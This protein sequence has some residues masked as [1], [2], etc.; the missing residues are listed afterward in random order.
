ML[1]PEEPL[2][3]L[4]CSLLHDRGIRAETR[5][6]KH[7]DWNSV[8]QNSSYVPVDYTETFIDYQ[9][10][11]WTGCSNQFVECSAII[12]NDNQPCAVW[13]VSLKN[14]G[15][16]WTIGS[17]GGHLL[18]PQF[19]SDLARKTQKKV[20]ATCMDIAK[21]AT[22]TLGCS[23]LISR[24]PFTNELGLDHWYQRSI[25]DAIGVSVSHDLFIDLSQDLAQ[26]KSR[27]RKRYK[28]LISAGQKLWKANILTC[29]DD[30]VWAEYQNLHQEVSG[31]I[32]RSPESWDKQ[33]NAIANEDAFLIYLRDDN[34]R[35]I[36]GGLFHFTKDEGLYAVGAY[37]RSLFDKPLGHVVQFLA[38][39]ELKARGVRW[40]KIGYRPFPIDNPKPTDKELSIGDF[41]QGFA[42]H[43]FPCFQI[44]HNVGP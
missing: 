4:V 2:P 14:N 24:V 35:M 37:D 27:I 18:P 29:R 34:G 41:K 33:L 10:A 38:I 17:L 25:I 30:V 19:K 3:D 36:G 1:S 8:L 12:Y 39:Q 5:I 11:Y 32:T 42:S 20:T 40:Y 21:A 13:P 26:I 44:N 6:K 28:S 23:H 31:R 7:C 9:E 16:Q 22:C 43:M 15:G